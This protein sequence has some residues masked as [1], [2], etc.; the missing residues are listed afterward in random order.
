MIRFFFTRPGISGALALCLLLPVCA[1]AA[2]THAHTTGKRVPQPLVIR[3]RRQGATRSRIQIFTGRPAGSLHRRSVG[4]NSLHLSILNLQLH[5]AYAFKGGAQPA[6]RPSTLQDPSPLALPAPITPVPKSRP[7]HTGGV[8]A[9]APPP[10]GSRLT[11]KE[12][13]GAKR[14]RDSVHGG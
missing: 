7:L 5:R 2:Q 8:T 3:P 1:A 6:A 13:E 4:R 11:P 10:S 12:T 9:A 14:L